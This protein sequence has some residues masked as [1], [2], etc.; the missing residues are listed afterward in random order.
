M[1]TVDKG[2]GLPVYRLMRGNPYERNQATYT[3][4][5]SYIE[6]KYSMKVST[7]YIAYVKRLHGI[8]MQVS[9]SKKRAKHHIPPIEK[10]N[11]IEDALKH[12][13]MI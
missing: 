10:Q 5:Q 2:E 12:Y 9:R 11:A 1:F 6:D 7:G 8:G 4:I 13:E 3:Q